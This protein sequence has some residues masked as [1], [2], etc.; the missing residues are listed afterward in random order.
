MFPVFLSSFPF[1]F[2]FVVFFLQWNEKRFFFRI[3]KLNDKR[4]FCHCC[5]HTASAK[6]KTDSLLETHSQHTYQLYDSLHAHEIS[7]RAFRNERKYL[8]L[9]ER[10]RSRRNHEA[11]KFVDLESRKR[12]LTR[13]ERTFPLKYVYVEVNMSNMKHLLERRKRKLRSLCDNG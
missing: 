12:K 6:L 10:R 1:G 2:Y 3:H 8:E 7:T 5:I 13:T 4:T 11:E 9:M